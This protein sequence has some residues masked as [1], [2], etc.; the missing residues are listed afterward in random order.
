MSPN[1]P[2]IPLHI[3]INGMID[4]IHRIDGFIAGITDDD[5]VK[6]EKTLFAV[7][8]AFVR[9]GAAAGRIPENFQK[10]HPEI[11]WREIGNFATS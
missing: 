1:R 11:E 4:D 6:D 7:C 8:Y 10:S 5:F 3:L 2:A 9:L